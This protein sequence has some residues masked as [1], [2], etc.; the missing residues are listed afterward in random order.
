MNYDLHTL[1]LVLLVAHHWKRRALHIHIQINC[2]LSIQEL[3]FLATVK[4]TWLHVYNG[5]IVVIAY[6]AKC[7]APFI[8]LMATT[9][10]LALLFHFR[11]ALNTKPNSP[12][13]VTWSRSL[14]FIGILQVWCFRTDLALCYPEAGACHLE[15]SVC[16]AAPQPN[17]QT[18]RYL[19]EL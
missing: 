3:W 9:S 19:E 18:V 7:I 6:F 2:G 10:A 15:W 14:A 8:V 5:I 1:M 17:W 13:N 4:L 16:L 11:W 12:K